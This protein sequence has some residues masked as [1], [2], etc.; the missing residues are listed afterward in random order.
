MRRSRRTKRVRPSFH[1]FEYD[2]ESAAAAQAA[3]L[4]GIHPEY[5]YDVFK[6]INS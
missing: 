5:T 2:T 4:A 1:P 6:R 3:K